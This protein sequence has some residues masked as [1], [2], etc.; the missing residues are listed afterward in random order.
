MTSNES[1]AMINRDH[2]CWKCGY[3]VRGLSQEGRCPECGEPVDLRR[4]PR[5][6]VWR[7]LG[8]FVACSV[9]IVLV[10]GTLLL[11]YIAPVTGHLNY[12]LSVELIAAIVVLPVWL[13][14]RSRLV[15]VLF[16]ALT[17]M[18]LVLPFVSLSPAGPYHILFKR[19]RNG[20]TQKQVIGQMDRYF[21]NRASDGRPTISVRSPDRLGM[22]LDPNHGGYNAEFIIIEFKDDRVVDKQYWPD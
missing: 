2:P 16:A 1:T 22:V 21:P 12:V 3:N 7:F 9:M 19:V 5:R 6:S 15:L 10:G 13:W 4:L 11:D 8:I 18:L 14:T 20:M 17:I